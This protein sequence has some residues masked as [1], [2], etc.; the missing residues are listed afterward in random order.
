MIQK[1]SPMRLRKL[2][3]ERETY[4]MNAGK[5]KG[6]AWFTSDNSQVHLEIDESHA[7]QIL[8]MCADAL[9]KTAHVIVSPL[10]MTGSF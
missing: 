2:E 7:Q 5:L 8:D 1:K 3:I 10:F 4:G 6:K 9:L